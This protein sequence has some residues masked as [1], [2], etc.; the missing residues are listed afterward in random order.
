MGFEK[1]D[2]SWSSVVIIVEFHLG[3][4]MLGVSSHPYSLSSPLHYHTIIYGSISCLSLH[5][6]HL[7]LCNSSVSSS[8]IGQRSHS[9]SHVFST[10]ARC[11]C[12]CMLPIH[13]AC[14][15]YSTGSH[16][17]GPERATSSYSSTNICWCRRTRHCLYQYT[18]FSDLLV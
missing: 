12:H 9:L 17:L 14:R 13:F 11:L 10:L 15:T 8:T 3:V 7:V 4:A 5:L 1:D 2:W 6:V 18:H 16:S